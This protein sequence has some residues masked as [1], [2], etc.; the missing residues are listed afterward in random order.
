MSSQYSLTMK[1][2]PILH[3]GELRAGEFIHLRSFFF[4]FFFHLQGYLL[5]FNSFDSFQWTDSNREIRT[6]PS[7]AGSSLFSI[8]LGFWRDA[9]VRANFPSS[10]SYKLTF[11]PQNYTFHRI[12]R[13]HLIMPLV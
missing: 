6:G 4:F 9:L 10:H 11:N 13:A 8:S 1:I 2:G 3:C 7:N 5:P 12:E